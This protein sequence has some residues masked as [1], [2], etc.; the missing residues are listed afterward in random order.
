MRRIRI[1]EY[2]IFLILFVFSVPLTAVELDPGGNR[3]SEG[4]DHYN[5][6][7]Y[8]DSLRKYQEAESYFPEDPRLEFNRGSV[9][10]KSGNLDKAIRHFE[11]SANSPTPELQWRSRFN[12]GNSYMRAGDRKK[13]AEEYIK[14]LKLN[15]DLKEARKNL[16]YL[17]QNPPPQNSPNT[18]PNSSNPNQKNS[19]SQKGNQPQNRNDPSSNGDVIGESPRDKKGKLTEEEAKRIL[20]SLDLNQIRRK[21]RK[22]RDREVFW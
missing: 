19:P 5:Q 15:P 2:S 17:R 8:V 3:I 18:S 21:S 22:S 1:L 4:L 6:G 13:A 10:F 9:E 12:L 20:D 7:E 16:E 14:A 11:K